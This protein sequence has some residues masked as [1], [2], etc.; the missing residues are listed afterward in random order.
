MSREV[1]RLYM[2]YMANEYG[3]IDSDYV[4]VNLWGGQKGAPFG[5]SAAVNM[6]RRLKASADL[7]G[8]WSLHTIRHTFAM[9]HLK[10]EVPMEVISALL[11]HRSKQTTSDIYA[12]YQV[13]DLRKQLIKSGAWGEDDGW[14]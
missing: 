10:H 3:L 12:R 5:Y 11:T 7:D 1:A 2:D 6:V 4:F 14:I 9:V 8:D 13:E